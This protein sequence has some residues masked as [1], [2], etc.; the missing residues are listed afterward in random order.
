MASAVVERYVSSSNQPSCGSRH[1]LVVRHEEWMRR[2]SGVK[3]RA[4]GD[5]GSHV[6][7][8]KVAALSENTVVSDVFKRI[9]IDKVNGHVRRLA[10]SDNGSDGGCVLPRVRNAG[11]GG[12]E[13]EGACE[14]GGA[15]GAC[16]ASDD[17]CGRDPLIHTDLI[18]PR[19]LRL[20]VEGGRWMIC[21]ATLEIAGWECYRRAPAQHDG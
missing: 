17:A 12:C 18:R 9:V 6:D 14:G 13:R 8:N 3:A 11:H 2:H 7:V 5:V 16:G 15:C 4:S 10:P 1:P 21:P 20:M 19:G